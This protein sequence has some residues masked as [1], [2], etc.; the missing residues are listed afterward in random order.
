VKG[1]HNCGRYSDPLIWRGGSD[2]TLDCINGMPESRSTSTKKPTETENRR[3]AAAPA[4]EPG[5]LYSSF[6]TT[7]T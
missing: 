1:N 6:F 5:H 3:F 7:L 2:Q 4:K